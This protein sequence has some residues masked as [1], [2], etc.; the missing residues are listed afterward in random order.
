MK[1]KR[2]KSGDDDGNAEI[3]REDANVDNMKDS[4]NEKNEEVDVTD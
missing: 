1:R 2:V 4:D 3:R